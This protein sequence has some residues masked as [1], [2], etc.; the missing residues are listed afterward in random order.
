[1]VQLMEYGELIPRDILLH[2]KDGQDRRNTT[3]GMSTLQGRAPAS[4]SDGT[5]E[6]GV[7]AI[8]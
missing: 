6:Q 1:M 7:A 4:H 5:Y 3:V 2:G 8:I